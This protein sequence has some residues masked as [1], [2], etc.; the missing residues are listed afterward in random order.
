MNIPAYKNND[1]AA[2]PAKRQFLSGEEVREII[3][4]SVLESFRE[5][6]QPGEPDLVG[7]LID[8]FIT[9]TTERIMVIRQAITDGDTAVI[10]RE[11]HNAKGGAGN[12]GAHRMAAC[13][14]ELEQKASQPDEAAVSTARMEI[15]FNEVIQVLNLVKQPEN[16]LSAHNQPL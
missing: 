10:K 16:D 1:E 5:F 4:L 15:E 9:S 8:L 14:K 13:C 3:D 2:L 12:I 7:K 11:A 6:Q